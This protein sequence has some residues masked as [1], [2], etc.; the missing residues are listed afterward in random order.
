M[1]LFDALI[2]NDDRNAGNFLVD[3]DWNLVLIDHSRAL[4]MKLRLRPLP[5]LSTR[6]DRGLLQRLREL[7]LEDLGPLLGDLFSTREIGLLL[8]QRDRVVKEV[9]KLLG[10]GRGTLFGDD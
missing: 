10:R 4:P 5:P 8:R 2:D 3:D 9:D 1:R 7:D 6:F